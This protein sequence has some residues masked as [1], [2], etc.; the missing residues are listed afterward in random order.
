MPIN[1]IFFHQD[2]NIVF[3]GKCICFLQTIEDNIKFIV[4]MVKCV[5]MSMIQSGCDI[6]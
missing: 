3:T 6:T 1:V 4:N 2:I 5:M